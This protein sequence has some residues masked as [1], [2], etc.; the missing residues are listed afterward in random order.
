MGQANATESRQFLSF[1]LDGDL[2]AFPVQKVKEVLEV[3]RI[4]RV[5]RSAPYLAGIINLRGGVV[6]VLDLCL[7]FGIPVRQNTIESAIVI[8]E[9]GNEADPFT[10][11][12]LVDG[13]KAVIRLEPQN[14]EPP[15]EVGMRMSREFISGIGKKDGC[16]I[17]LLDSERVFARE[18]LDMVA[19]K[20]SLMDA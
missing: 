9:A 12:V 19:K 4:T 3:C 14:V 8:I 5:P 17:I 16:F 1:L 11:G 10:L 6:P 13:V 15:P 7:K 18:E 20:A 2:F